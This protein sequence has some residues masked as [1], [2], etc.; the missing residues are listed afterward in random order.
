MTIFELDSALNHYEATLTVIEQAGESPSSAVILCPLNSARDEVRTIARLFNT[1]PL[2]GKAATENAVWSKATQSGMLHLAAHGEYNTFNPLF[3]S[4]QL[5][6][7]NQHDGSLQVHEIYELDLS[8]KTNLVVLSA[9]QTKIG[10]LSRGD[11]VVGM[12]RAFLYAGTPTVM[13]SLWNVDDAA[14]GLLM[15]EFY[16]NL[17]SGMG[18]AEALQQ[19]Q[20]AVRQDYPHPYFWAAFSL[21]GDVGN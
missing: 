1:Q 11:E 18:K 6:G 17:Q 15:K 7:D 19:A 20:K 2:V 16:S 21:T 8:S 10:E 13:S 9:C 4:I 3:S 14:T 12:N 5:V